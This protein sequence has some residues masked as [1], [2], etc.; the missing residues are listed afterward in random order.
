[1]ERLYGY[2]EVVEVEDGL[3]QL[4]AWFDAEWLLSDERIYPVAVDP[5]VVVGVS[6]NVGFVRLSTGRW[7]V[8]YRGGSGL[9]ARYSDDYGASWH[10]IVGA[11]SGGA[12]STLIPRIEWAGVVPYDRIHV[13]GSAG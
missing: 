2:Y 11:L 7:V 9:A 13:V 12:L 3:Q 5:P 1:G 10:N 8:L 4:F 6:G